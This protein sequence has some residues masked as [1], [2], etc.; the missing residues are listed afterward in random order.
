MITVSVCMIVKNE[1]NV[2]ARCLNSLKDLA[3]E[4]VIVDTG[5]VDRTKEIAKKYT[6]K[7][8][9]FVWIDDFSAARNFAFSK[10][11]KEYIYSADADE[12]LD[13]ENQKRFLK[14]K[15][16]MLPEIEIVQ[17][18]YLNRSKNFNTTGNFEREYRP[19]LYKRLRTFV[20]EDPIHETVRLWPVVFDSDIEILHMPQSSHGIRDLKLLWK[21]ARRSMGLPI[22]EKK[23]WKE[24]EENKGK[25]QNRKFLEI[26]KQNGELWEAIKQNEES[27]ETIEYK[28]IEFSKKLHHMYAMELFI[29]GSD[30]DFLDAEEFFSLSQ[31]QT[32]RTQEEVVEAACVCARAARLQGNI[33]IFFKNVVK[34]MAVGS[35]SEICCELGE[36]YF[37]LGDIAEAYL[38]FYNAAFET[39]SVLDIHTSQELPRKRLLEICK[40]NKQWEEAAEWEKQIQEF[41]NAKV[42]D[43]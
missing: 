39:E 40:K 24:L 7:I 19:K 9:D 33:S 32:F 10:C 3:E 8:F 18:Y 28:K 31:E 6:D 42:A 22:E 43:Y 17:M 13:I 14:L 11:T 25:K 21:T 12:V 20:W 26:A 29:T 27:K 16:A 15:Q 2:L 37:L 30:Q 34:L 23:E 5:S 41:T 36:Y 4:I 35:C 38:W 1:E